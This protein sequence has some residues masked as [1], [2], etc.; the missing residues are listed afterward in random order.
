MPLFNED[1]LGHKFIILGKPVAWKRPGKNKHT[2][3]SY[4]TQKNEK[5]QAII[6]LRF[7]NKNLIIPKKPIKIMFIFFMGIP[8]TRKDIKPGQY[9]FIDPDISN[10]IKFFEDVLVDASI[11]E[12]DNLIAHETA[13]K[14]YSLETSTHIYIKQL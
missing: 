3:A 11:I 12:D 1:E 4:D 13:C 5:E 10:L 7:Q 14:I 8:K 9:H 2:G 6:Q